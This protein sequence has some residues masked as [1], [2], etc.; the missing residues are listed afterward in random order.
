TPT[1]H[2]YRSAAPPLPAAAR[3]SEAETLL[4]THLRAS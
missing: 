3:Q 1:G 2:H 4:G